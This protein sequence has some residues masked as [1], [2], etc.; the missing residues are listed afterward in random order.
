MKHRRIKQLE[1]AKKI[2]IEYTSGIWP[3]KNLSPGEMLCDGTVYEGTKNKL[4]TGV[5]KREVKAMRKNK[6]EIRLNIPLNI[7]INGERIGKRWTYLQNG[8]MLHDS[9][10]MRICFK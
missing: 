1:K 7:H 8:F 3:I 2:S 6:K 5:T 10:E 4:Y 9:G